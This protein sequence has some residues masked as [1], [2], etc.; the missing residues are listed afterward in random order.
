[1]IIIIFYT[2][3]IILCPEQGPY[4]IITSIIAF[5]FC[6]P[7]YEHLCFDMFNIFYAPIIAEQQKLFYLC[8]RIKD[9][10]FDKCLSILNEVLQN[11]ACFIENKRYHQKYIV[12]RT[13]QT[14]PIEMICPKTEL[15]HLIYF[16]LNFLYAQAYIRIVPRVRHFFLSTTIRAYII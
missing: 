16:T 3:S 9:R 12:L 7:R 4:F 14:K 6:K 1:M 15:F 10:D 13:F 11:T 2:S 8:T 5:L